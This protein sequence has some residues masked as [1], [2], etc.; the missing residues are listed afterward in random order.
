MNQKFFFIF[1]LLAILS[2]VNAIPHKR[3]LIF[4]KC[5]GDNPL[6]V[7]ASPDPLVPGGTSH[8]TV[9]G[10][11][12]P[13]ATAGF[14]LGIAFLDSTA[15][16]FLAPPLELDLCSISDVE[17]PLSALSVE[18]PVEVPANLPKSYMIVVVVFNKA[19]TRVNCAV[20]YIGGGS[21]SASL[22]FNLLSGSSIM[23]SSLWS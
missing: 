12:A 23:D 7:T 11:I 2:V 14:V 5:K 1:V 10:K 3:A 20:S 9:S 19:R 17:C 22:D 15:K 21:L 4:E 18:G 16:E 8:F 13:P 6:Y